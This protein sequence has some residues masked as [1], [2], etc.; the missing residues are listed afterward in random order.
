MPTLWTRMFCL[1]LLVALS[2]SS[3]SGAGPSAAAIEPQVQQCLDR[4]WRREVVRIGDTAREVLWQGPP[5]AWR[6]GAILVLHGGGGRHFQFCVANARVVAPQVRFG[7]LAV[8]QG[9]AVFLIDSTDRVTDA[10][11]R[12]CGKIWDDEVRPRANLDLP[13]IGHVL[14]GAIP[15]LRPPGS[16]PA[17]FVTGLSS[18]GYMTV[19]A[20]THFNGL[21]TAFAPV[22]SGDPY[23]WHRVCEPGLTARTKVHGTGF[24]NE[25]GKQIVEPRSCQAEDYPAEARWD[26]GGAASKP[27]FRLFRHE[28][29]GV[30][31]A[32]C[33]EKVERLL[34][35]HGYPGEADFLLRGGRR[36]L[37][38][39]L[40]Q[41]AYNQP[42]LD[43]FSARVSAR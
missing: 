18:G 28:N 41:D 13:L 1:I 10:Q 43:F 35:R 34:R 17:I 22:S 7:D 3:G 2:G 8:A 38:N 26:D 32:S 14:R 25:T 42:I 39:H 5:G 31:D 11:G 33:G 16:A 29:D 4:G 23:G 37:L 6:K 15:R 30:N 24:D 19:R 21:V 27:R 20:A 12:V 36:S 9:F 40:W